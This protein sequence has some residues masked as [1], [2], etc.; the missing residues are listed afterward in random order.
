MQSTVASLLPDRTF[1]N[2]RLSESVVELRTI[3]RSTYSESPKL[4]RVSG[5]RNTNLFIL[6]R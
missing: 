1:P 2:F 6:L 3:R 5:E 4:E